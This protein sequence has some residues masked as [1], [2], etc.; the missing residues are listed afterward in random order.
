MQGSEVRVFAKVAKKA[1]A[2]TANIV[3]RAESPDVKLSDAE[4][5]V[6]KKLQNDGYFEGF[7]LTHKG[8]R[9]VASHY[10]RHS[11]LLSYATSTV[12]QIRNKT[13][14][15]EGVKGVTK[16]V[17]PEKPKVPAKAAAEK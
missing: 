11:Q 14:Q 5:L 7:F 2:W 13:A 10:P 1:H 16:V 9:A 12:P 8:F 17:E 6:F 4:Q 15:L 3:K